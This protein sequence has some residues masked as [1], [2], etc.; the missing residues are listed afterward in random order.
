MRFYLLIATLIL[1]SCGFQPIYK[2]GNK[3]SENSKAY[4]EELA[5]I[6]VSIPRKKINQDLKNNLEKTL[7]PDDI[8]ADPKYLIDLILSKTVSS[9]LTTSTGSS[10][11]NKVTLNVSYRLKD[12]QSGEIIATGY[13]SAVDDFD[14]GL[15]R[16][17]NYSTEESISSNLT[18]VIAQNI[19]NLLINDIV[20]SYKIRELPSPK[21]A[22]KE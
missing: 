22:E 19:R 14:V 17:A 2:S 5:S 9:T 4:S 12:L 13:T 20:N 21:P 18:L 11:R 7:N 10:G 16:F 3:I 15:N 1:T 8:Q 6:R